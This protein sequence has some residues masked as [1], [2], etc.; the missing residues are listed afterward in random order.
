[1]E[2]NLKYKQRFFASLNEKQKRH[3]AAIEANELG[4]HGVTIISKLYDIHPHT[5]RSGQ[6]ELLE[7]ESNRLPDDQIRKSGGGRKK[8]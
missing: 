2:D 5:I 3:F 8:T 7:N 1:M 4:Y 6:K